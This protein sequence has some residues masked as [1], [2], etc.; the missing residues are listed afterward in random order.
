MGHVGREVERGAL[1]GGLRRA[2]SVGESRRSLE[3]DRAEAEEA[4]RR[5]GAEPEQYG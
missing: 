1:D 4:E 2:S 5:A 3:A